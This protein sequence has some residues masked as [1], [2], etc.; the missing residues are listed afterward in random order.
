MKFVSTMKLSIRPW[1][2]AIN[3][4]TGGNNSRRQFSLLKHTT[5]AADTGYASLSST[6]PSK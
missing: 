4:T 2:L 6:K 1:P 5:T 3:L